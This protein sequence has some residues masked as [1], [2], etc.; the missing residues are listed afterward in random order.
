MYV[1]MLR[2][3]ARIKERSEMG[4]RSGS[5]EERNVGEGKEIVVHGGENDV[6]SREVLVHEERN[7][8]GE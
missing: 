2:R 7:V 3:P 1:V 4:E 5:S 8:S 6:R